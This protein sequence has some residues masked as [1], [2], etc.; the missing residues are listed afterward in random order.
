[1]HKDRARMMA[2]KDYREEMR[3]IAKKVTFGIFYGM[4]AYTLS[5]TAEIG[6][7]EAQAYIN[8]FFST[9]ERYNAWYQQTLRTL[10]ATGEVTSLTGRKRRFVMLQPNPRVLKQA[11]NFPIQSTAGDVTLNAVIRLHHA[12]KP[13]DCHILFDVHDAIVFEINKRHRYEAMA[14]IKSVM[15]EPAFPD[16]DPTFPAIPTDAYIGK[17]WGHAQPIKDYSDLRQA[18]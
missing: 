4:E 2:D 11:V 7:P 10:E 6:V 18:V 5:L 3:T 14:L 13:L 9:N 1:M 8:Q 16:I 12:L 15:E 17:S